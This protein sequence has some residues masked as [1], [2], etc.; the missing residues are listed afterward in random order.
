M[1]CRVV[2]II[3]SSALKYRNGKK[4]NYKMGYVLMSKLEFEVSL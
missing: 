3:Y 4:I 1:Q 2:L